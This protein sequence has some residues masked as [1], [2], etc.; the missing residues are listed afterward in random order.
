[1]SRPF[2]GVPSEIL[3]EIFTQSCSGIYP[4]C[5]QC[6]N[7]DF[8]RYDYGINAF[9]IAKYFFHKVCAHWRV[10]VLSMPNLWA[11]F[12]LPATLVR[13]ARDSWHKRA[14]LSLLHTHLDRSLD[15]PLTIEVNLPK[16]KPSSQT[17]A[18]LAALV[19]HSER[20]ASVRLPFAP[21]FIPSLSRLSGR[22]GQLES[23]D[24]RLKG[25]NDSEAYPDFFVT[26]RL[27]RL[28]LGSSVSCRLPFPKNQ[29]HRTSLGSS[30]NPLDR[31]VHGALSLS[32]TYTININPTP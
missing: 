6:C 17:L 16:N 12:S 7:N 25:L 4:I 29:A 31:P 30:C 8:A 21:P 26:P 13:G 24:L 27:R 19:D 1:M 3:M 2:D 18:I 5:F 23:L 14:V 32:R 20:W 28:V 11:S 10:I 22:L 15:S 9:D